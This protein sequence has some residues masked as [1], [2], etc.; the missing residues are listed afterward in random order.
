MKCHKIYIGGSHWLDSP[1]APEFSQTICFEWCSP[2]GFERVCPFWFGNHISKVHLKCSLRMFPKL[3]QKCSRECFQVENPNC[4]P[5][6][7]P[8]NILRYFSQKC[9]RKFFQKI[10][11]ENFS[12]V[13]PV[14]CYLEVGVESI[15]VAIFVVYIFVIFWSDIWLK[16]IILFWTTWWRPNR[17]KP[18]VKCK[19]VSCVLL[20]G[21][22]WTTLYYTI[23]S[24]LLDRTTTLQCSN[25]MY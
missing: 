24:R 21:I 9:F 13:P 3:F 25:I 20:H 18:N 17:L 16:T 11:P 12:N 6:S 22:Q 4:F 10:S 14:K 15:S 1:I 23:C 7:V 2:N 8:E 5:E 19:I